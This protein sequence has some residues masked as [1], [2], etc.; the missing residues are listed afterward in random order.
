MKCRQSSKK[1]FLSQDKCADQGS[2]QNIA[3]V[4]FPTIEAATTTPVSN[5]VGDTEDKEEN[6]DNEEDEV[7]P[8][9]IFSNEEE[10]S[11]NEG[12]P[13]FNDY[14]MNFTGCLE[15]KDKK[16]LINYYCAIN[17]TL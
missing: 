3:S 14:K 13:Q 15:P 16:Y 4:N 12:Q 7:V 1:G 5:T 2:K 10:E 9:N 11:N 17:R 8:P 6:Q